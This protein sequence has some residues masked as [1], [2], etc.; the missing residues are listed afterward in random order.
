MWVTAFS[1]VGQA[2]DG[3]PVEM[4]NYLDQ[5]EQNT[6]VDDVIGSEWLVCIV[7]HVK[8]RFRNYVIDHIC[9]ASV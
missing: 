2:L 5:T 6:A 3:K 1:E 4:F 9:H 7:K 8:G